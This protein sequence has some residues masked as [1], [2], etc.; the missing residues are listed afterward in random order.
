MLCPQTRL[1][2][3]QRCN[4]MLGCAVSSCLEGGRTQQRR[5]RACRGAAWCVRAHPQLL[6]CCQLASSAM[7]FGSLSVVPRPLTHT[8]VLAGL[9]AGDNGRGQLGVQGGANVLHPQS[10]QVR[11]SA[12]GGTL[13]MVESSTKASTATTTTSSRQCV[14][15]EQLH[16]GCGCRTPPCCSHPQ[17]PTLTTLSP[18][19]FQLCLLLLQ[20]VGRWAAIA[21][22]DSHAA[23]LSCEGQL[24]TWGNNNRGQLGLGDKSPGVVDTPVPVQSLAD[25]DVK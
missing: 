23:G 24:Y 2:C 4:R 19:Y 25:L 5:C 1:C 7:C 14:R 15:S 10:I 21:I 8:R 6:C 9:P 20:A 3:Q 11:L 22:S 18:A 16:L 17:A 13:L 12:S